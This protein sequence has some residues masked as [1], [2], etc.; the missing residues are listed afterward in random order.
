MPESLFQCSVAIAGC[1]ATTAVGRGV[2]ALRSALRANASGLRAAA[3]FDKP[4]FQSCVVGAA[5]EEESGTDDPAW[6][7]AGFAVREAREQARETLAAIPAERVGFV[8]STTKANIE[9]MERLADHRP[10]SEAAR[11]HLRG[12]ALAADLA[13][14]HGAGGPVQCVSVACVSGLVAIAQGARLIQRG[15]ADAVMVAGVD[16]LSAF[17]MAG[18]SALKALD[19]AGCR[20][21]DKERRG[22]SPGEAGAAVVL[23]RAERVAAPAIA[24]A[25][26]GSSNDANHMTG[27][28]RDGS[29]LAQ[30]IRGALDSAGVEP[31]QIDYINAHGTGTP[32]NDAMEA[33]ALRGVFGKNSPPISGAKGMLGHTL[34]AAGVVETI[35]CVLAMQERLLPGTARL[36]ETAEDAPAGVMKAPSP[37]ARL[38]WALKLNSGFG[39]VNGALILHHG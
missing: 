1:G 29:G 20:P 37:C 19:P 16:H 33:A 5:R 8:L 38:D 14:A 26:W 39:G 28:A 18:F 23:A 7:L 30:A 31:G 17:V 12:D 34:G 21:F 15:A 32:Y 4:A 25:G 27:P 10:C 3:R 9:A 36:N 6:Q 24:V 13:A 11:R 35:L 2:D 22:L